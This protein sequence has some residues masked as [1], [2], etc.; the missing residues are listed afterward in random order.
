MGFAT[1]LPLRPTQTATGTDARQQNLRAAL[2]AVSSEGPIS[3]AEIARRTGLTAPTV[4]SLVADL[5]AEG[6]VTEIGQGA[7]LGGKRPTLLAINSDGRMV[8]A[9][10][11]SRD[12]F[13][14]VLVDLTGAVRDRVVSPVTGAAGEAAVEAV[15]DLLATLRERAAAPI[16][17]VGIATPGLVDSAATVVEASNL[18]W[19]QLPLAQLVEERHGLPVWLA[20]D[21]DAAALAEFQGL[22]PGEE[23]VV[24]VRIARGIGVGMVL[25]GRPYVGARWAAGEIGHL[26]VVPGGAP[27]ACGN[28]GC[29]E[30]VAGSAAIAQRLRIPYPGPDG[31]S[32]TGE[33]RD[34][35]AALGETSPRA[36]WRS[37]CWRRGRRWGRC[38]RRSWRSS[39]CPGSW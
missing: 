25:G 6:L 26:T 1:T 13:E 14:G 39:T 31:A 21:A 4:S 34:L 16:A 33:P 3:R 18:G 27:C 36:A 12:P 10:D 38:W 2:Q 28:A 22:P 30:T 29:L 15:H 20:N 37:C 8:A 35:A 32:G 7:S 11:L 17:G 23:N 24:A 19:H 5:L 9:L